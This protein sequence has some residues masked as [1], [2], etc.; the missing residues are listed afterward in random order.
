MKQMG[1][2]KPL[3][4]VVTA[5]LKTNTELKLESQGVELATA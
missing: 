3:L 2:S 5:T 1:I 4:A